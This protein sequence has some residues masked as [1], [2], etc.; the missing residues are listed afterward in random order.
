LNPVAPKTD[1]DLLASVAVGRTVTA[2]S[3]PRVSRARRVLAI[4]NA[5]KAVGA[6]ERGG[7]SAAQ[8]AVWAIRPAAPQRIFDPELDMLRARLDAAG[9]RRALRTMV[10]RRTCLSEAFGIQA[11]LRSLGTDAQVVVGYV[12]VELNSATGFHA[13]AQLRDQPLAEPDEVGSVYHVVKVYGV[14]PSIVPGGPK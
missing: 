10:G 9:F 12:R 7:S 6:F 2:A 8:K 14:G 11:G 3:L 4:H 1:A 5:L 13:W